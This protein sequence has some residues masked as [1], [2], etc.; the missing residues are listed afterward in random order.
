MTVGAPA[1]SMSVTPAALS[2][3]LAAIVDRERILTRPIDRIAYASDASF[4]R[5]IPRAV[6]RTRTVE[7]IQALFHF[8]HEHRIP[9]TFR[10][11]GTSL[12]G[13]A[14]TDGI[15]V[16][17]ARYWRQVKVEDGGKKV[18]VQPGVIGGHVNAALRPYR[19]KMGPDPASINACMV[20]GILANNSSGMCCG[21]E[22][23]AY[24]TLDSLT[25]VLPSGT[26]IDTADA[27]SDEM[28]RQREPRLAQGLLDLRRRILGQPR[29]ADRIRSKYRIKNT[30]G[31]SLNAFLDYDRPV[32]ILE[33]LLIGSEGT[34]AFIAEAVLNT[35][36]DLPVKYTGLLL[37]PDL[38]AAC[39][40]IVP[41]RDAGAKAL[42]LMDRASLRSV[43]DQP[44]IPPSIKGLPEGAAGLLAEFQEADETARPA[45]EVQAREAVGGLRLTEPARF[46]HSPSEQ[47]QLWKIR[48]GLFPSVGAVRAQATTVIIEDV[49]FPIERLADGTVALTRLFKAHGYDNGIIF[50]HAKDGNLHFVIT[51][52]LNEKA[53]VDQYARFMEDMIELVVRRYDGALKGEHGTGRNMAPFVQTE[54][55]PEAYA[56]MQRL[57]G[58]VDPEGLLNPGV[59]INPDPKAHLADIKTMPVVEDEVD[60]CIECGFCESKCPSLDLTLTPRQRIAVRREMA[61]LADSRWDPALLAGLEADFPY[62]ALDTCAVDGLCAAACPVAIDTGQLTKRFRRLHHSAAA[63]AVARRL[64]VHFALLEPTLRGG[65]RIGHLIQ[66][67]F[68]TGTMIALTRA[69]RAVV[70]HPVPVWSQNMPRAA[71]TRHPVTEKG[72]A[73]AVY[74]PSCISR[75]MGHLPGE[76][77]EMSLM[78][79]FVTVAR[80]ASAPVWI[81]GDVEGTCCGVPFSSKGYDLAHGI[82][83]NRAITRLWEWSDRGRL[84]IVLDTSPC[85]YGLTTCR[86]SLTPENQEKFGQLRILDSVGFVHDQLLPRL[87]IQRT[88]SSVA[89]HPVC[90]VIKTNLSG[91][92]EGIAHACSR[93]VVVP[94]HAGCCGFA[95]DRGFLFP[96]LTEAATRRETDELQAGR[97]DGYYS[98]SRTCEIGMTRAT[99]HVYRSYLYL[100]E[101]AS[102]P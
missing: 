92:L 3:L 12:S 10:A 85:T 37:F 45:L 19:A 20:G 36:P 33:H 67:L 18:R 57:K 79:A 95:G 50:G 77:D 102:R 91:K 68:G 8:S 81:P 14:I 7:E 88:A 29:L 80:R 13:Q 1:S 72:G 87:T 69:F 39:A 76:P 62:M 34:L 65:L 47:A 49:V 55:G 101:H 5:L 51:P 6:V 86:A 25:F 35:V 40:S 94:L 30:T 89:L 11:A 9:L 63:H 97:Y 21:V 41:L 43:E 38:Y 83:V 2:D 100:L 82:A 73:Q 66:S 74:F 31:Y 28:L 48:Q 42:E 61:R 23:N 59:I 52:A 99:G 4:Y 16:E 22:Q 27:N 58:L 96:E 64:A 54:W 93:D 70:R 15:L 46:T 98:S 32:K 75:V 60:K 90:S 84:P 24:H 26:V 53:A 44:G 78:E 56:I 17:V 71:R